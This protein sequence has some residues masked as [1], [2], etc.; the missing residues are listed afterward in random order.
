MDCKCGYNFE[1]KPKRYELVRSHLRGSF[2]P[3]IFLKLTFYLLKIGYKLYKLNV[4]C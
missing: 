1:C 2:Q 4:F 3:F